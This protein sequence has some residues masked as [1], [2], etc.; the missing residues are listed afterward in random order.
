[1]LKCSIP[2]QL[3]PEQ[4]DIIVEAMKGL[5]KA[6]EKLVREGPMPAMKILQ[7]TWIEDLVASQQQDKQTS[8]LQI[9]LMFKEKGGV[10]LQSTSGI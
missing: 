9:L 10:E 7:L 2:P 6:R 8:L 5:L 1:M 4:Q 3:Q